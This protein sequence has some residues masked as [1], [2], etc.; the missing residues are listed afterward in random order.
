MSG[1]RDE[2]G[3]VSLAELIIEF[4][5]ACERL[6]RSTDYITHAN[7]TYWMQSIRDELKRRGF[8]DLSR[9]DFRR[10]QVPED[11]V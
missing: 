9:R 7:L 2:L 1:F 4:E 6:E 5:R 10:K 8:E 3:A 11:T